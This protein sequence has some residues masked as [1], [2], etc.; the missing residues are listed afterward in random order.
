MFDP[1]HPQ[2]QPWWYDPGDRMKI[3]FYLLEPIFTC[4]AL[5]K[6]GLVVGTL[7]PPATLLGCLVCVICNSKYFIPFYSNFA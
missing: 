7:R 3:L 5:V 2:V 4:V 1:Q 6:A